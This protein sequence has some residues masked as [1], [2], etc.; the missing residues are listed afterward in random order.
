MPKNN[1]FIF[2]F[3]FSFNLLAQNNNLH[4]PLDIPLYL[5]GTFGELRSNHFHSGLD[6]KTQG[7][8]GLPVYAVDDGYVYRIKISR[9]GYGKALYIKHPS[10]LVSVYGHLKSFNKRIQSY[11]KQ[12]QYKKQSF[13][14]EVFP[15]AIELR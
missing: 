8:E 1:F 2:F 15:Y 9:N 3:W 13:E 12:K 7:K 6:I 10:G 11:I 5:S 4:K 14:I